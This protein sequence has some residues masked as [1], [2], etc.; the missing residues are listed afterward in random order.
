MYKE[1]Y[2]KYKTK[3]LNL[4]SQIGGAPTPADALTSDVA[5]TS[6]GATGPTPADALTSNGAPTPVG[7]SARTLA[8][9]DIPFVFPTKF[10]KPK[11]N[12]PNITYYERVR[13]NKTKGIIESMIKETSDKNEEDKINIIKTIY[14]DL[15][16]E[17]KEDIKK[18]LWSYARN[19]TETYFK[20]SQKLLEQIKIIENVNKL[21]T[22]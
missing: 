2:L 10:T 7:A 9:T 14:I 3:Y 12:K 15:T 16:D 21:G 18:E 1:K 5:L 13:I 20:V 8:P 17:Q 22:P 4:K 19:E 11:Q 6:D